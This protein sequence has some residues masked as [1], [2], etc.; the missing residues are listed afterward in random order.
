MKTLQMVCL[1]LLLSTFSSAYAGDCLFDFDT[2]DCLVKAEQGHA[3]AQNILGSMYRYGTG[4]A[5]DD[6][7]AAE[8]FRLAAEQGHEGAKTSL[9]EMYEAGRGVVQDDKQAVEWY[10]SA[11]GQ[12]YS[13]AQFNLGRMYAFGSGVPQD[14]VIAHMYF[15]VAAADWHKEA[16][17]YRDW[18]EKDMTPSQ[19]AEAR[20][21]AEWMKKY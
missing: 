16:A 3:T 18:I 4:V 21:L 12:K 7:Q 1:V 10:I 11:A 2:D 19:I 5:Q 15:N 17:E 20:K 8:L 6:R 9:G 14:Y 13:R